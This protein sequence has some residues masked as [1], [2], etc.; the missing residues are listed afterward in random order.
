MPE[1][2]RFYGKWAELRREQLLAALVRV[3]SLVPIGKIDPLP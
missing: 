1:I 3:E 2:C